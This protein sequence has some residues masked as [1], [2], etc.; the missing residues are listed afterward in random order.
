MEVLTETA[1][2]HSL[3]T[4][5]GVVGRPWEAS[6]SRGGT[7]LVLTYTN[8]YS[9]HLPLHLARGRKRAE[10]ISFFLFFFF[11]YH[12]LNKLKECLKSALSYRGEKKVVANT[13][14]CS[15]KAALQLRNPARSGL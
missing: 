5:A 13:V 9:Y 8:Q 14:L 2:P 4:P 15:H 1:G 3:F 10:S 12:L 11:F 7:F 6:S